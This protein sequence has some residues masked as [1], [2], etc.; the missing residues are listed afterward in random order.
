LPA[1][2]CLGVAGLHLVR[3]GGGGADVPRSGPPDRATELA[4]LL[5]A[6]GTAAI[7]SPLGSPLPP[8]QWVVFFGLTGSWFTAV[9]LRAGVLGG[10]AAHHV[11]HSAAM[12]FAVQV[13]AGRVVTTDPPGEHPAHGGAAA[14]A[15][16]V[17]VLALLLAGY[18]AWYAL[19]CLD[20][21]R[22]VRRAGPTPATADAP[23]DAAGPVAVLARPRAG[24][25]TLRAPET[26]QVA[27]VAMAIALSTMMLTLI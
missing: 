22:A 1:V 20:R 15:G 8:L 16:P 5:T 7:F 3:L 18:F 19:R 26:V 6:L 13:D 21:L 14:V 4:H 25:W 12:V 17:A 9:A 11:V 2:V 10:D 24:A 23:V 27:H